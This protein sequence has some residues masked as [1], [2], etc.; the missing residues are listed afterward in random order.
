[1]ITVKPQSYG[2]GAY[3]DYML[4][5]YQELSVMPF[6]RTLKVPNAAW[7]EYLDL[8]YTAC[9]QPCCKKD[10]C[11]ELPV[12]ELSPT[13]KTV[14]LGFSGGKD[15]AATAAYFIDNKIACQLYRAKGFN[16]SYPVEQIVAEQ[17][18]DK[19]GLKLISHKIAYAGK[20][21]Y[22]SPTSE[23]VVKDQLI[24]S[25]MIDYMIANNYHIFSLGCFRAELLEM[26]NANLN[27]SDSDEIIKA[28]VKAVKATFPALRYI[29]SPF[30]NTHHAKAYLYHKHMDWVKH[31]QSCLIPDRH[32]NKVRETM[33]GKYNMV[34]PPNRC[35]SCWKCCMDAYLLDQWGFEVLPE[36]AYQNQ[37]LRILRKS[38]AEE[39][40]AA[41][42]TTDEEVL[43]VY[44]PKEDVERYKLVDNVLQDIDTEETLDL[45]NTRQYQNKPCD[46]VSDFF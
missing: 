37:V 27:L 36:E 22:D 34:I 11:I 38:V 40:S 42:P 45:I 1:M 17:F 29:T 35:L 46:T 24:M 43:D 16:A 9:G 32:R 19:T 10:Y 30:K 41:K 13:N 12:V 7:D 15:S 21:E 33:A 31:T 4:Y 2:Y 39:N 44:A 14:I 3:T 20:C 18:A 28:F 8:I 26:A 6:P 5:L 25:M 23:S